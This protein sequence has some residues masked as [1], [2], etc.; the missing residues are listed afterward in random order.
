MTATIPPGRMVA[1]LIICALRNNY[2]SF[3]TMPARQL[4]SV[5]AEELLR[6]LSLIDLAA[7]CKTCVYEVH[8]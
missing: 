3:L 6:S 7:Y 2:M 8:A 5:C 1:V 4:F